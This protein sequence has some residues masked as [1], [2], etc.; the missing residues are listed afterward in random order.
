M[1]L[2]KDSI[3]KQAFQVHAT[4]SDMW[5]EFLKQEY[6]SGKKLVPNIDPNPSVVKEHPQIT[7]WALYNKSE[8]YR[9]KVDKQYEYW[10]AQNKDKLSEP[11]SKFFRKSINKDKKEIERLIQYDLNQV[12]K[13]DKDLD[14][15]LRNQT[16][17]DFLSDFLSRYEKDDFEDMMGDWIRSS[18][19]GR[20]GGL[21]DYLEDKGV[22]GST[23][24]KANA[25]YNELSEDAKRGL[26]KVYAFQQLIFEK[27]GVKE[28]TLYRGCGQGF[29]IPEGSKVKV[30]TRKAS[31]FTTDIN[32]A[33]RFGAVLEYKIPVEHIL[34]SDLVYSTSE[35]E[36]VV[37]GASE[38]EGV[39]I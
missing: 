7:M 11:T 5:D 32:V 2:L 18:D 22:E 35:K 4:Q 33:K 8:A 30:E 10:K 37:L 36:M 24:G 21:H 31:S 3:T 29:R 14:S 15:L 39:K 1:T 16:T 28:V 34:A 12:L 17:Q 25:K 23:Y 20:V 13:V 38:L 26:E 6:A 9:K 19:Y 27:L